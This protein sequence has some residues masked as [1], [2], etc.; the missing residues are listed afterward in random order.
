MT[1]QGHYDACKVK[2]DPLLATFNTPSN[3][4]Y[5]TPSSLL[6]GASPKANNS[7]S[8]LSL[9]LAYDYF[10]SGDLY[11]TCP[12]HAKH[13]VVLDILQFVITNGAR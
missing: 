3:T 8:T 5:S 6:T 9:S 4:I 13:E 2:I 1:R 7:K 12:D 11:D 10:Y